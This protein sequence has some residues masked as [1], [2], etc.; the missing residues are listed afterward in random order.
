MPDQMREAIVAAFEKHEA[1]LP[2][3]AAPV[4]APVPEAAVPEAVPEKVESAATEAPTPPV[5]DGGEK[6]PP[7]AVAPVT[8][9]PNDNTA[10]VTVQP[11]VKPPRSWSAEAK[12]AF[13]ALPEPV[14]QDVLRREKEISQG[15]ELAA[16]ARK[17][18]E[19]FQEVVKPFQP[20]FDAYGV[21]D[22]LAAIKPL[23]VTR[24]T[25]EIG[26]PEQKA[27]LLANLVH[28]F[29]VDVQLLDSHLVKRGPVQPFRPARPAPAPQRDPEVQMLLD[30]FKEARVAKA[31]A[32]IASVESL[33]H[34]EDLRED[35]ADV[36]EAFA[37]NGKNISL[38]D[39]YTRALAMNPSL[40]PAP[41][42]VPQITKSQAAAILA[43]RNAASSISGTPRTGAKP[44]P[45]DRRSQIESAWEATRAS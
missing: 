2:E 14:K 10:P 33:P 6:S 20:L 3:A 23:L 31:E 43:S 11:T 24:A 36:V 18:Y 17:H 39:A 45:T 29:G 16:P 37:T 28:E 25:L 27:Q 32:E 34:F 22:P 21:S 35:I 13:A 5:K 26:N 9:K 1:E 12:A 8:Q 15:L 38:K 4:E 41:A 40:E 30:H 7:A 44:T 42:A 19:S